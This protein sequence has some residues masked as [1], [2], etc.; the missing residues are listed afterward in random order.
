MNKN[1]III[2]LRSALEEYS[3]KHN[4]QGVCHVT[5]AYADKALAECF[6]LVPA[7]DTNVSKVVFKDGGWVTL[8]RSGVPRKWTVVDISDG[9]VQLSSD[10]NLLWGVSAKKLAE[11][12]LTPKD[13]N[14][15]K[16]QV[17]GIS[18]HFGSD[19]LGG[20]EMS[21]YSFI[22]RL[23][24]FRSLAKSLTIHLISADEL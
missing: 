15:D 22:G 9:A 5:T 13:T 3:S 8:K 7:E 12:G 20:L 6:P 2:T 17:F 24:E 14:S 16:F 21:R 23:S 1:D 18:G 4:A 19:V 11:V 10:E